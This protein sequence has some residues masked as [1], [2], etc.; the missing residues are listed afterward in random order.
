[1]CCWGLCFLKSSGRFQAYKKH[2]R[3]YNFSIQWIILFM[4]KMNRISLNDWF[5][6]T[7]WIRRVI[8]GTLEIIIYIDNNSCF[9][10]ILWGL[11]SWTPRYRHTAMDRTSLCKGLYTNLN[12]LLLLLLIEMICFQCYCFIYPDF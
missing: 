5:F 1:M 8:A 2:F 12:M 10:I 6:R 9:C 11:L 3:T 7:T 4:K